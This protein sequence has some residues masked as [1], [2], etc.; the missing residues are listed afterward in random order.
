MCGAL[1]LFL[2]IVIELPALY[3]QSDLQTYTPSKLLAKGKMDMKWYNNFYTQTRSAD[4]LGVVSVVPRSTFYTFTYEMYWGVSKNA[5]FNIGFITNFKSNSS[6]PGALDVFRF[7]EEDFI[8]RW[9]GTTF[10]PS[11]KWSPFDKSPNFSVQSSFYFPVFEDNPRGFYLDKR[12]YVWENKLFYDHLFPRNKFQLFAEVNLTYNF[13]EQV[14]YSNNEINNQERFAN[15]S[16]AFPVS[17]FLSYFPGPKTAFFINAQ[18]FSLAGAFN[19]NF[20]HSGL[21][22]KYQL[23]KHL[24]VEVS[25]SYFLRGKAS[26]LGETYNLGFRYIL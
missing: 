8:A 19:Q 22:F 4:T 17:V 20:T 16:F 25:S 11:L 9:G 6:R 7:E 10:A 3:A 18:H 14:D 2:F 21:G 12:S 15:N 1:A 24:N 23:A 13:G 5:K 26:G